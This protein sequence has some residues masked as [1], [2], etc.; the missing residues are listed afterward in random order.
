MQVKDT[1][2]QMMLERIME[3]VERLQ[4]HGMS[5]YTVIAPYVNEDTE[6]DLAELCNFLRMLTA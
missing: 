6:L 4:P 3:L 2:E 1:K 5:T